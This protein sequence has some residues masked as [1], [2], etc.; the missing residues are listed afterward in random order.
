MTV[1]SR[2]GADRVSHQLESLFHYGTIKESIADGLKLGDDPL[3]VDVAIREVP[4]TTRK[5]ASGVSPRS[6]DF[7]PV[8]E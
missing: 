3:L 5:P 4:R 6:T 8:T 1:K 2:F 7:A